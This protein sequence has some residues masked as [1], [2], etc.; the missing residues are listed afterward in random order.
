MTCEEFSRE[1]DILYNNITSNQAPGLNEYE[2]SVFLTQ[3][4]ESIILEMY[5]EKFESTEDVT[6]YL[7]ALVKKS[8]IDLDTIGIDVLLPESTNKCN[9]K[10]AYSLALDMEP[11][12]NLWFVLYE[13]TK[14]GDI[15]IP[16][17][18]TTWDELHRTRRNPF[19]KANNHRVLR[20]EH[21]DNTHYRIHT[22]FSN[23][24]INKYFLT[25]LER[26]EPIVTIDLYEDEYG[27][28]MTIDSDFKNLVKED[29]GGHKYIS[30]NECKLN[31]AIH[32]SI[33]SRAVQ[34]AK[35]VWANKQ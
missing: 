26:P 22:L 5:S 18:P 3:A 9:H 27:H 2:K 20:V 32:R 35:A 33:L 16:V 6:S 34:I 19:R 14:S 29:S 11:Y 13:S 1:F 17:V 24:V 28:L 23:N 31:P 25:F 12:K 7:N 10:Y 21:S 8:V 30:H 4:Q 15:E